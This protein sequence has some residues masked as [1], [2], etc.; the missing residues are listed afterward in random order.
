MQAHPPL[1]VPEAGPVQAVLTVTHRLVAPH[2]PH[3]AS[4]VQPPQVDAMALH[5]SVA[6][7][8]QAPAALHD[9]PD[10]QVPQEL[11]QLSLPQMRP[12]QLQ[13]GGLPTQVPLLHVR[14]EE[15]PPQLVP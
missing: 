14:P 4:G 12:A 9:W 7:A 11:P 3:P 6:A 10:G 13:V 15:Q 5:G 8:T 1:Q 2:H